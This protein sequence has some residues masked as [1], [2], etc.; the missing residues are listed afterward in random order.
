[1]V[2][3]SCFSPLFLLFFSSRGEKEEKK[4][5]LNPEG[6]DVRKRQKS[7]VPGGERCVGIERAGGG[8]AA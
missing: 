5:G 8:E 3:N 1:M 4:R 7:G 2:L 6:E